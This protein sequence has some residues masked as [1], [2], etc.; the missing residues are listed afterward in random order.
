MPTASRPPTC[1]VSSRDRLDIAAAR[2][3]NGS[4]PSPA[5]TTDSCGR[6][7]TPRSA[8]SAAPSSC[9]TARSA[10]CPATAPPDAE[11]VHPSN[12][13][14]QSPAGAAGNPMK[15]QF[16]QRYRLCSTA[17]RRVAYIERQHLNSDTAERRE[18]RACTAC[19]RSLSPDIPASEHT[20]SEKCTRQVSRWDRMIEQHGLPLPSRTCAFCG[21]PIEATSPSDP[22]RRWC[23]RRC[24]TRASRG[25]DPA[26]FFNP[27]T[28]EQCQ[29]PFQRPANGRDRR[30][31]S[32]TC[33]RLSRGWPEKPKSEQV[34]SPPSVSQTEQ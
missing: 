1:G 32:R 18:P 24:R 29:K 2:P 5:V 25:H 23:S 6:F 9:S 4:R 14:S 26:T 13:R 22:H 17:C 16:G 10:T 21:T 28:C 34:I 11:P 19:E 3:G 31:C 33:Y 27:L 15:I 30:W 20:C 8:R 7:S 12:A